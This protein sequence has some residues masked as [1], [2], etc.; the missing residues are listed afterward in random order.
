M[1]DNLGAARAI[2]AGPPAA[3]ATDIAAA[4]RYMLEQP[5]GANVAGVQFYSASATR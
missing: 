5:E 2:K 4:A 1:L 3:K